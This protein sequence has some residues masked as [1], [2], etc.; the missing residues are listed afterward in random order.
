MDRSYL[1]DQAVVA[2]S[3]S[4]VCARLLSFE[5]ADEAALMRRLMRGRGLV[6][7]V[8]AILD[9][10]GQ[11]PLV[12]PGRS[13]T[14]PYKSGAAMAASM[15]KI[16]ARY[17]GKPRA[18]ARELGLPLLRDVR[19]ALNV[20]ECDAQQLV[21]LRG[22]PEDTEALEELLCELCWSDEL[23]GRFLYCRADDETEWAKVVGSDK[24]P[25]TGLLVVRTRTYGLSGEVVGSASAACSAKK[26]KKLLVDAAAAFTP[27]SVDTRRLRRRGRRDGVRWQPELSLPSRR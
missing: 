10:S 22:D 25:K 1:S 23:I 14:G 21:V 15:R 12:R 19:L 13:P 26:L 9:P 2:A 8:F 24:A 18:K 3:R 6:N 16:A 17:P 7:T 20:T 27:R 5:D 11:R 4:F